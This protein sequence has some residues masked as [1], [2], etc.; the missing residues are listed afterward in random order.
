MTIIIAKALA[1]L[2]ERW[3]TLARGLKDIL[4]IESN[5]VSKPPRILKEDQAK[6]DTGHY[7]DYSHHS[8]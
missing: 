7:R 4:G 2:T 8:P 3:K 6:R 5:D 1:T